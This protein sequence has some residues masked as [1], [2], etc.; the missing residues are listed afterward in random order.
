MREALSMNIPE[1]GIARVLQKH[2][3]GMITAAE[4]AA[5]LHFNPRHVYRLQARYLQDG[6]TDLI[7]G[8]ARQI[9]A[10]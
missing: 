5:A 4:A 7:H 9:I 1:R 3:A 2:Q 10:P 6:D 8:L